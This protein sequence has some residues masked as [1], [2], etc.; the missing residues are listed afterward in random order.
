MNVHSMYKYLNWFITQHL[1]GEE[2]NEAR[3]VLDTLKGQHMDALQ[4]SPAPA[5]QPIAT[6]PKDGTEIFV[7]N[8]DGYQREIVF[9]D[10]DPNNLGWHT[11]DG[12]SFYKYAGDA[13][14][15]HSAPE[16]K[17]PPQADEVC[18]Y[19]GESE[20]SHTRCEACGYTECDKE[21]HGDHDL[22]TGKAAEVTG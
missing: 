3:N 14:Y 6:A 16:F 2:L 8:A 7:C 10:S 1:T 13:V 22:C 15:W 11:T 17:A 21:L 18:E 9:W 12:R 4:P 19:C 5:W 20:S